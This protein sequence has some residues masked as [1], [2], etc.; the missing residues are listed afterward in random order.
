MRILHK[1][2]HLKIFQR[3]SEIP[4]LIAPI[5]S[6]EE[7]IVNISRYVNGKGKNTAY[8]RVGQIVL[9]KPTNMNYAIKITNTQNG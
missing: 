4:Q 8:R 5:L 3:T 1:N 7:N 9:D 6:G 2:H